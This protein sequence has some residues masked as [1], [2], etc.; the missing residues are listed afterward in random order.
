M[1]RAL[2]IGLAAV[3]FTG[4]LIFKSREAT[5]RS[6]LGGRAMGTAWT[7]AWR[8]EAPPQLRGEV[9]GVLE[10]WEQVMSQWRGDSDLSR[11]NRGEAAS[12]DLARVIRLAEAAREAS[13][14]AFD[15][16]LLANVHAA[17]YGPPGTGI[18]LS[19]IGKGFAVDRVG[20]RLRRLGVR[21]FVFELGG[22]VVAGEGGWAVEIERPT[23]RGREISR[24]LTL[25]GRAVA[26]SGNYYQPGHIIDPRTGKPV[27]RA[28]SSVTVI[29]ADCASADAWATALFVLGPDFRDI[30][31]GIEVT[32][33]FE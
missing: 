2:F 26:T 24:V 22:E 7:L 25:S 19:A 6:P 28:A 5:P 15:H 1:R 11:F 30:P 32:W 8:G 3:V 9:A 16:R 27:K 29:A 21:D 10:H 18:D 23:S 20:E 4:A 12:A 17:G 13:G 14:G 31:A 33:Q